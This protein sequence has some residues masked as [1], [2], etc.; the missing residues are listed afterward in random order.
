MFYR[1]VSKIQYLE[2]QQALSVADQP[3][4]AG[5]AHSLISA[6]HLFLKTGVV[7]ELPIEAGAHLNQPVYNQ[8]DIHVFAL[9]LSTSYYVRWWHCLQG[10]GCP[11][12]EKTL[13]HCYVLYYPS[14]LM[15]LTSQ[16]LRNRS[17]L[18]HQ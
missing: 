3:S 9:F 6:G 16:I 1:K 12:N 5:F 11:T 7:H 2:T 18:Q 15:A 17:V 4:R 13:G 14:V 8:S 10:L